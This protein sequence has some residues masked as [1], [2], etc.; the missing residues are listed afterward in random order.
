MPYQNRFI[1][2]LNDTA[3]RRMPHDSVVVSGGMLRRSVPP[4]AIRT[5][6]QVATFYAFACGSRFKISGVFQAIL[7]SFSVESY[8]VLAGRGNAVG[9]KKI[10]RGD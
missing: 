2:S 9:K 8:G 10:Q 7:A 5:G 3:F 1:G 6:S 4:S